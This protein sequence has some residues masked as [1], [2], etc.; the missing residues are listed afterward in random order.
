MTVHRFDYRFLED[1]VSA[2]I[3]GISDI[4][5]DLHARGQIR[6]QE[7]LKVFDR[8]RR[9][10]MIDSVRS[11]N[12]IEGI[13]TVKERYSAI[14]EQE[15]VPATHNEQEII[16]YQNV[17]NEIYTAGGLELSSGLIRHFHQVLLSSTS[18]L[19]G[20]YKTENNW[21]QERDEAGHISIRFV[22]VP[23]RETPEAVEQLIMAYH[24]GRQDSSVHPLMLIACFIVDFLCIHPFS[25]GNGRISR[26]LTIMLLENEGY[27]IGRYISVD[28]MIHEYLYGYYDAL[29]RASQGWHE[30]QN[31]YDPFIVYLMQILYRCYKELDDRFIENRVRKVPKKTQIENMLL[32][33]YVPVS[34]EQI[35]AKFPDI[36]VTTIERVLGD[37]VKKNQIV[38]IGTYRNARY[39]AR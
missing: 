32:N 4:I 30:N 3:R 14:L 5:A 16:G 13:V 23:A 20:K 15:A 24:E 21:I 22:P 11:S 33:S 2:E 7:N 1:T 37:M 31:T 25:D 38:K 35:A 27:Q 34:K 18:R 6:Q 39:K 17:L 19:A 10:A 12:A 26:L 29:K 28:R 9:S 8:L 36:S